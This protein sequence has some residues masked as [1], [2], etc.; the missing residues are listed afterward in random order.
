MSHPSPHHSIAAAHD[1]LLHHLVASYSLQSSNC[2]ADRYVSKDSNELFTV[3]MANT[4]SPDSGGSQFFI[5]AAHNRP[6]DWF[7]TDLS[8][9]K[10]TGMSMLGWGELSSLVVE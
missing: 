3:A 9:S 4:G 6:L 7:E 10:H 2:G 1:C 8:P 5:N